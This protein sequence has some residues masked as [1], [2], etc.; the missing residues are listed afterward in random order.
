MSLDSE[1]L[2]KGCGYCCGICTCNF[3]VKSWIQTGC[4]EIY[5][6]TRWNTIFGVV[7]SRSMSTQLL[8]VI[9]HTKE[10]MFMCIMKCSCINISIYLTENN[11]E[12]NKQKDDEDDKNKPRLLRS[13]RN[14]RER[15]STGIIYYDEVCNTGIRTLMKVIYLIYIFMCICTK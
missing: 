5:L 13:K 15:R 11:E 7:F 14:R 8:G 2:S 10:V 4:S 12:D 6:I 1:L 3:A 9:C